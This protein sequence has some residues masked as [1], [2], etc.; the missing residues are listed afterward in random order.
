MTAQTFL[1]NTPRYAKPRTGWHVLVLAKAPVAG[2][3]KTRLTPDLS[4]HEAAA[5]AAGALADTLEAVAGCGADR[6]IL[7]LDG[8]PGDWLPPGFEVVAQRGQGLGARLAAAWADAAGPGLQ[9]GMDTPQVTSQLL[10]SCLDATDRDPDVSASLGLA[11]D[12]GWW[13]LG[14]RRGWA[15]DPFAGV[16]MSTAGTGGAQRARLEQ[17]G[18]RVAVLPTLDDVDHIAVAHTVATQIPNSHFAV[19]LARTAWA[20]ST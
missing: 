3:V 2:Q 5:V 12:G 15:E 1:T 8:S 6:R 10:D 14:L 4:M 20:R 17:L 19:A 16:S 13:A 11:A 7:A 18:H 9:I